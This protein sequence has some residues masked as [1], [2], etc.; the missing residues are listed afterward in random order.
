ML[1]SFPPH[2]SKVIRLYVEAHWRSLKYTDIHTY[3]HV[4]YLS[5]LINILSCQEKGP[6][7]QFGKVKINFFSFLHK[8][9]IK[10][11]Y[12]LQDVFLKKRI[13]IFKNVLKRFCHLQY[14]FCF[15]VIFCHLWTIWTIYN[16]SIIN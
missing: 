13:T 7:H 15:G 6:Q 4:L 8:S 5:L 11:I 1:D 10:I 2:V 12:L 14:N 9:E 3:I 16:K